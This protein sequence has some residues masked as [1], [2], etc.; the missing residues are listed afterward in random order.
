VINSWKNGQS[1]SPKIE[2]HCTQC[3]ISNEQKLPDKVIKAI[4]EFKLPNGYILDIGLFDESNILAGIEIKVTHSIEDKKLNNL[5]IPFIEVNGLD[6]IQNPHKFKPTI[7]RFKAFKC[8]ECQDFNKKFI[9]K[10]NLIAQKSLIPLP[11]KFYR[12]GICICWKCNK[13]ILVFSWPEVSNLKEPKPRTIQFKYSKMA[14]EKYWA[15]TCPYCNS[16]QGNFFLYNEPDGPFFSF[17]C[18]NDT[19]EDYE[20][21][22]S[23]ICFYAKYYLGSKF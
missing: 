16:I 3:R 21:D 23:F 18:G 5:N 7:D 12:F 22:I 9:S 8:K 4:P 14:N 2:R 11:N 19:P 15:N 6:I 10:A 13:E 1:D 20:K 17:N